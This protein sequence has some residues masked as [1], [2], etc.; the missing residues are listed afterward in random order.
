M[1]IYIIAERK[2]SGGRDTIYRNMVGCDDPY[3]GDQFPYFTDKDKA[4]EFLGTL[5]GYR[6]FFVLEMN[7]NE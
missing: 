7:N 6:G 1:S 4:D 3:G 2:D 5:E